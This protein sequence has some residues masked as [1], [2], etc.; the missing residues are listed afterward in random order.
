MPEVQADL[1]RAYVYLRTIE[2]RVQMVA[3]EQTHELPEDAAALESF[4]RFSGY[5][6]TAA[7]SAALAWMLGT[8]VFAATLLGLLLA[9][10]ANRLSRRAP[11]ARHTYGL[12][13]TSI[14]AALPIGSLPAV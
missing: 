1:E 5:Q 12:R 7:L 10:G 14:L 3:D 13:R 9:W 11:T 6:N 2:H 8:F 4:A